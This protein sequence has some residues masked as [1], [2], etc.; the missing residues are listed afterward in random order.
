MHL[1]SG[2][3]PK[4]LAAQDECP[5]S[6]MKPVMKWDVLVKAGYNHY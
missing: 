2:E 5:G 1:A 6:G 4:S 3:L